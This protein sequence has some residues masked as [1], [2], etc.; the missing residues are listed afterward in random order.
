MGVN[1][2]LRIIPFR[3][4]YYKLRKK[5]EF[6]VKGLIY[7]VPDPAFP[8]LGVHLTQTMKGWVEAGPTQYWRQ[9]AKVIANVIFRSMT[10]FV[11][12]LPR[13]LENECPGMEN[14]IMGDQQIIAKRSIFKQPSTTSTGTIRR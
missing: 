3:G 4:E 5:S 9:N 14:R 10:L 8:F 11:L 6:L 2:D 1:T 12:Y 7:P 13:F